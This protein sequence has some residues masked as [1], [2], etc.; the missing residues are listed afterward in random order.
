MAFID[1][2]KLHIKAGNGGDG[3]VRWL[4]EKGKEFMGP[5]G[6]NGGRGAD[7]YARAIRD[8]G[9]LNNYKNLKEMEGPKGGDGGKKSCHGADG[10]DLYIDFPVGSII[11]NLQ[12]GGKIFLD[13]DGDIK[14]LA[15][16]GRG[17]LGNEN[18]KSSTNQRPDKS[19]PG[20][21]GEEFDFYIEVELVADAGLIGLP[22]AGKSSLI[23]ELTNAK[24]KVGAYQFTTLEPAL[25]DMYGFILADLPGLIEGAS[26]G[27][28]LG[29]KFLR[30]IK[31]TKILFHCLSL[32]S[33]KLV[34][35]YKT[36][37]KELKAYSQELAD[38][39]EIVILTKTDMVDEKTL[40][41]AIKKISKLNPNILTVTIL[42]DKSVKDLKD[43]LIKILR[44]K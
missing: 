25:G 32:E 26:E 38:K 19:S 41:S 9:V 2:L 12:T 29:D 11:T 10:K 5:A 21:P 39:K 16:G 24:S 15:I 30:H 28:G 6:G 33:T 34:T 18:F 42:D 13:K 36:I 35:D 22:N 23:N 44:N 27:K 14:L 3:V 31:R 17:G 1:E 20:K 40:Q 7:V 8:I 4:H 43:N 37:R